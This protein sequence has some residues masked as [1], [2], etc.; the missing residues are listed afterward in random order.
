MKRAA[1][2]EFV[3][4][5]N[6][7][8]FSIKFLKRSDGTE[9]TMVCRTGVKKFLKEGEPAY[10]PKDHNLIWVYDMVKKGYRSIPK[11][12]VTE[13]LLDGKWEKVED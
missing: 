10:D 11:D 2:D 13:I 9:R 12:G 6:G 3:K 7:R 1:L 5:K 4:D 8:I